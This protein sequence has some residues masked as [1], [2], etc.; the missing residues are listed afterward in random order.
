MLHHYYT[1]FD[2][3]LELLT[4]MPQHEIPTP[5]ISF[6]LRFT[7][8]H[9]HR[10]LCDLVALTHP[11]SAVVAKRNFRLK[12]QHL[13]YMVHNKCNTI[14]TQSYLECPRLAI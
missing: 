12:L 6:Q 4:S 13:T 11:A 14:P 9:L 5:H 1:I 7:L 3:Y 10:S 2:A 8:Y